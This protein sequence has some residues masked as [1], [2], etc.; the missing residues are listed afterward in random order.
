MIRWAGYLQQLKIVGM[1]EYGM[2]NTGR[3]MHAIAIVRIA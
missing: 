2:A 3:L 1:A